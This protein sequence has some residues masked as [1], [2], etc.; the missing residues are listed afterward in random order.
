MVMPHGCFESVRLCE[1][2]LNHL[3]TVENNMSAMSDKLL[4]GTRYLA[5]LRV[6]VSCAWVPKP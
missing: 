5:M 6:F 1:K 3:Q 4:L 2:C